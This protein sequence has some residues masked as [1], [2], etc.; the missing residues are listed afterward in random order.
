MCRPTD[1][2]GLTRMV[3][4]LQ[5]LSPHRPCAIPMPNDVGRSGEN[6]LWKTGP[7]PPDKSTLRGPKTCGTALPLH[8]PVQIEVLN[9][10]TAIIPAEGPVLCEV[11]FVGKMK[12]QRPHV[13]AIGARVMHVSD[14]EE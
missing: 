6:V 5:G 1:K 14:I 4:A 2:D 3:I 7:I 13:P 11:V 10:L 8:D 12:F 9:L